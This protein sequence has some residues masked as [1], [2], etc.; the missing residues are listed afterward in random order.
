MILVPEEQPEI[1]KLFDIWNQQFLK[2]QKEL[3]DKARRVLQ[4]NQ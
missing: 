4:D 1:E 2:R 3:D